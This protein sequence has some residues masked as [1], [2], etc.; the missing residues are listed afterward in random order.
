[1]INTNQVGVAPWANR[2]DSLELFRRCHRLIARRKLK[3]DLG[4][5]CGLGFPDFAQAASAQQ[6]PQAK[7]RERFDTD[8]ERLT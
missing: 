2:L 1:L 3:G 6:L 8:F 4:A 5:A 7:T